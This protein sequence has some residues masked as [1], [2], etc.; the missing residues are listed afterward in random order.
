VGRGVK[1]MRGRMRRWDLNRYN[2]IKG[3]GNRNGNRRVHYIA[4]GNIPW[5]DFESIIWSAAVEIGIR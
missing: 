5:D 2:K 1:V 3:V 4:L